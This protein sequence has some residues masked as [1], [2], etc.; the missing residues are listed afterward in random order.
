LLTWR[1]TGA[2]VCNP[3]KNLTM[4]DGEWAEVKAKWAEQQRS[5]FVL[6]KMAR[7]PF[8]RCFCARSEPLTRWVRADEARCGGR[9]ARADS[10]GAARC[11]FLLHSL[12]V[13]V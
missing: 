3:A 7:A 8:Q 2:Q 9:H 12:A 6:Y 1:C 13:L 10:R 11:A 5:P 4:S